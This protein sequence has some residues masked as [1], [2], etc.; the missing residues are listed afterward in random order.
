MLRN[1]TIITWQEHLIKH[2]A[3]YQK[4]EGSCP[5]LATAAFFIR[6]KSLNY[7]TES[8]KKISIFCFYLLLKIISL[9][10]YIRENQATPGYYNNKKKKTI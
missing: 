3:K 7:E 4:L 5:T 1:G 10:N 2:L 9:I 8:L 6:I